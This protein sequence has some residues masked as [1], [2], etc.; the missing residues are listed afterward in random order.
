MRHHI[1]YAILLIAFGLVAGCGPKPEKSQSILDNPDYH[2]SQG[3][4]LLDRGDLAGA[5]ES[6]ERALSLDP[7]YAEG[8]S[9][10]ALVDAERGDF[11]EARDL[12][13]KGIERDRQNPW[14]WAVRG[15][16]KSLQRKGDKWLE[17]ADSDFA[18]AVE[19]D[20]DLTVAHYWWGLAKKYAFDFEAAG[21]E[22]SRVIEMKD[23][24]SGPADRE[25]ETVQKI[26]RATPGTR[27]GK[28]IALIE[29]I[30]RADIAVL[31]MEELKLAEVIERTRPKEYDT[32]FKPP[33]DPTLLKSEV[34]EAGYG[35]ADIEDTWAKSW[36]KEVV[37][38]GVMELSPDMKFYPEERLTRA[39][40]ALFLQNILIHALH[41]EDLA[42][43]YI[44]EESRFKDMSGGTAAYNAAAL[45]IDRGIMDARL[46][47]T[48]EPMATV[49][50][51]DAL[52]IIRALQNHL[53]M[54]F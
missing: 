35:I 13:N 37:E 7:K 50:G 3:L 27:V 18:R 33:E 51:A 4:R 20:P 23:E 29:Q 14:T 16:V 17:G 21:R 28:Q 52:L 54:T 49:S 32:S 41:E 1:R 48:F 19:M 34:G 8:F 31:F 15:R 30:D 44:V 40:F 6:F 53:R 5:R 11:D 36:I 46:D 24:W 9:G 22:F 39:E 47:G 43:K 26:L 25:Y 45:C 38:L 10:L 2:V 42:T 12:A